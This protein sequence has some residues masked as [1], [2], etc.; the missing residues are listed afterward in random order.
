MCARREKIVVI[1]SVQYLVVSVLSVND[2][3]VILQVEQIVR[4]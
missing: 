3:P 2:R 1:G 4:S